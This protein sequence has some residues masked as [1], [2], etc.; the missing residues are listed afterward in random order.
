MRIAIMQ[1]YFMPYMA[2]FQLIQSVDKL[3][4]LDDVAYING[5]W[6]NRNKVLVGNDHKWITLP[7]IGATQNRF[8]CDIQISP[9]KIWRKKAANT[10]MHAYC[11]SKYYI[12]V[13]PLFKK[14]MDEKNLDLTEFLYITIIDLCKIMKINTEILLTSRVFPKG[15]LNG[16]DRIIDI[17]KSTNADTY[18]NL[19]GG[20]ELYSSEKF[21]KEGIK[22]FFIQPNLDDILPSTII[23]NNKLS[24]L[25]ILMELGAV[26]TSDISKKYS[27][28]Q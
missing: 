21:N 27:L 11:R 18:V 5:G 15:K 9:E 19:Y 6:I 14:W 10:I 25:H 7:L 8:I 3:V 23:A 28:V 4:L 17:C 22:L 13:M 2:Y 26:K 24:I 12:E 16:E 20:K 1:P